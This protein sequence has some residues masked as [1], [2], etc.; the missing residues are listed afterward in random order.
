MTYTTTVTSKGTI[1]LPADIRKK[2]Q[3]SSGQKLSINLN[4]NDQV[5]IDAPV[6]IEK[7]RAKT[8]RH[9]KNSG[10]KPLSI[11]QMNEAVDHEWTKSSLRRDKRSLS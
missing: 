5:V 3:I 1:T 7:I 2:L 10:T 6:D 11:E 4:R 8:K 9:M